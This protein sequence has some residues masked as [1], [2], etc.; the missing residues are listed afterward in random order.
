MK[1]LAAIANHG[2]GNRQ[3]L[4]RLIAE[5]HAMPWPVDVVIVSNVPK[6]LG[7]RVEVRVGVPAKN[8]WSLP[9]AHRALFNERKNDYDLFIYSEDDTLV[10]AANIRAFLDATAVLAPDEIA[11]F[12]RTETDP[13]GNVAVSTAHGGF[14]WDPA[15]I[16]T[17]GGLVFAPYTNEH[18]ACYL[19]TRDHIARAVE[20]GGFLVEPY[21]GRYDMLCTAATDIYTRCGLKR[22]VCISRL[23]DFL[24][25]H[26]PNKYVGRMGV[27]LPEI[28]AEVR[29]LERLSSAPGWRGPLL[30]LE[31]GLRPGPW[32]KDLYETPDDSV[33][34]LI[35][36][37]A[38]R[39][40]SLGAGWG[41]TEA[42]LASRN[43]E[44]TA[45]PIDP[46]FGDAIRRRGIRT[47]EGA[48]DEA[49]GRLPA[50]HFDAVL[51][52]DSLQLAEDPVA[53]LRAARRALRNGDGRL[54]LSVPQARDVVERAK[55]IKYSQ[56][57]DPNV[58]PWP[59]TAG[60]VRGWLKRGG[61]E[62]C[63][64]APIVT[65]RRERTARASLGALRNTLAQRFV[66]TARAA[67]I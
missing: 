67:A 16:I 22:Y 31:T 9:F 24:L 59:G 35:P 39:V 17:R 49:V 52:V 50:G 18:A 13:S 48:I 27:P 11:G 65:P 60:Q 8:P 61:F 26:L 25:P 4:D 45:V 42:A 44:V 1:I 38:R 6:D 2:T 54:V 15:G 33:L 58:P 63:E 43:M 37:Q 64:F 41:A 12:M 28:Q 40:L 3:Y 20:S 36:P 34:R 5:Y 30:R 14:R 47:S 66:I 56:N 57:H 32:S 51:V 21:E 46:V 7:P 62:V 53:W 23:T 19:A 10:R 55:G 29:A